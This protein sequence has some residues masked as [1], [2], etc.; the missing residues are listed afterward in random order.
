MSLRGVAENTSVRWKGA[1][2]IPRSGPLNASDQTM[3]HQAENASCRSGA[4]ADSEA[5]EAEPGA[6]IRA[7][8]GLRGHK[9]DADRVGHSVDRVEQ[10][11]DRVGIHRERLRRSA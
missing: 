6:K 11:D 3:Y 9:R 2:Y 7:S 4:G 1:D 8:L 10:T 5:V